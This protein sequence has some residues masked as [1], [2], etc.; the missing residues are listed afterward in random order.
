MHCRTSVSVFE[1]GKILHL[2]EKRK[3]VN[4][5]GSLPF[6][7]LLSGLDLQTSGE[8]QAS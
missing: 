8:R 7:S 1:W 6:S 3:K 5:S 2:G 4:G